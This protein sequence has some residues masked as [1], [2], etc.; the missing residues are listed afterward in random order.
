MVHHALM[1]PSGEKKVEKY[2]E[3][4]YAFSESTRQSKVKAPYC[5][6]TCRGIFV[7]QI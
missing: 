4:Y 7:T 6:E 5:F 3:T 2:F 1:L